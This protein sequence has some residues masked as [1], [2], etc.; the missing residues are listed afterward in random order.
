MSERPLPISLGTANYVRESIK[1][2]LQTRPGVK[3]TEDEIKKFRGYVN[4]CRHYRYTNGF[5]S[6]GDSSKF[7]PKK[8]STHS[9]TI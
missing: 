7:I 1:D 9:E 8:P 6:W 5:G 4:E 3:L 2:L